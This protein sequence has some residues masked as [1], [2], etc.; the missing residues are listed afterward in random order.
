MIKPEPV[1]F[2]EAERLSQIFDADN[3]EEWQRTSAILAKLALQPGTV[4]ADV[5]AGTG[6]SV[7]LFAQRVPQGRV[8]AHDT[9]QNGPASSR[10]SV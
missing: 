8:Y 5:F 1:S 3:R 6:Y 4:I 2:S 10:E 7:Q 9:E